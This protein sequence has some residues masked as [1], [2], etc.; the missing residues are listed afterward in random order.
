VATAVRRWS[1]PAPEGGGMVAV[2]YPFML[3]T[4]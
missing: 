1:F 4:N 3:D 2:T